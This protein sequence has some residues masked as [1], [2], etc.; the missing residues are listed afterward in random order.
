MVGDELGGFDAVSGLL[1]RAKDEDYASV[2]LP[3]L[4]YGEILQHMT[5]GN[6][7]DRHRRNDAAQEAASARIERERVARERYEWTNGTSRGWWITRQLYWLKWNIGLQWHEPVK[8]AYDV[9]FD[10]K[11]AASNEK[12]VAGARPLRRGPQRR[13]SCR[14]R[15]RVDLCLP[16]ILEISEPSPVSLLV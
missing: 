7:A 15:A 5:V 10:L 3:D 12:T 14:R 8:L 2:R 13:S 6:F 11:K 1:G 16:A 4:S 9:V